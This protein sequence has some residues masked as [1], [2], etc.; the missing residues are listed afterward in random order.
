MDAAPRGFDLF[1]HDPPLLADLTAPPVVGF[2]YRV[3][4]AKVRPHGSQTWHAFPVLGPKHEDAVDFNFPY[5]HYHADARFLTRRLL[6]VQGSLA[7]VFYRP[8]SDATYELGPVGLRVMLCQRRETNMR[9]LNDRLA[10]RQ[11]KRGKGGWICPHRAVA[12]G[13]QPVI[14]GIV[15]CPLH[16]LRLD[17]ASGRCVGPA[18]PFWQAAR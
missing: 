12:L 5:Q 10:G 18:P 2:W 11:A 1:R 13:S 7:S 4:T 3:P 6:R 14:D 9:D 17:A 8:L 15:T 16:G